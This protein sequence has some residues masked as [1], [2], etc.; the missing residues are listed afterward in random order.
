MCEAALQTL[1]RPSCW[2]P[3]T[4]TSAQIPDQCVHVVSRLGS[5]SHSPA[6]EDSFPSSS[7]CFSILCCLSGVTAGVAGMGSGPNP[8]PPNL[9]FISSVPLAGAYIASVTT[10]LREPR[11][12]DL[13]DLLLTCVYFSFF[14]PPPPLSHPFP[15]RLPTCTHQDSWSVFHSALSL[16]L[17]RTPFHE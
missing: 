15:R 1:H 11:K 8:L 9:A 3:E 7:C 5:R 2:F 6:W 12:L 17:I 4:V 13:Q 16:S 10:D 14:F